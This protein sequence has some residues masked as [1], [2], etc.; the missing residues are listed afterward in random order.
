MFLKYFFLALSACLML[1]LIFVYCSSKPSEIQE[2]VVSNAAKPEFIEKSSKPSE[3]YEGDKALQA[4]ADALLPLFGQMSPVPV[5]VS[6]EEINK[7]GTNVERGVAFTKCEN[8]RAPVI[9]VKSAFYKKTNNKQIVNI[10]KHELT[11]AYF[12]RQGIK[13][14][15]D[16]RFRRKFEEVG[17]FGN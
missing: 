9:F 17:G 15:H 13:T 8:D 5:Y 2:P 3:K 10:L 4:K 11:H 6:D 16:A 1:S 12:C 14:G 7:A